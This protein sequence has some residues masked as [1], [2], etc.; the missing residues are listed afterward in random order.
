MPMP[1]THT[2]THTN[3]SK[4][5]EVR[6][7]YC[8]LPINLSSFLHFKLCSTARWQAVLISTHTV[9]TFT[10]WNINLS[11]ETSVISHSISHLSGGKKPVAVHRVRQPRSLVH[12]SWQCV[13]CEGQASRRWP[14]TVRQNVVHWSL[15]GTMGLL[16]GSVYDSVRSLTTDRGDGQARARHSACSNTHAY[17]QTETHIP[18]IHTDL[19]CSWLCRCTEAPAPPPWWDRPIG[20]KAKE[21]GAPMLGEHPWPQPSYTNR[22]AHYAHIHVSMHIHRSRPTSTHTHNHRHTLGVSN[23]IH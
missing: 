18:H 6:L 5:Q 8:F 17:W 15:G 1:K 20:T 4:E 13:Y 16:V 11:G 14:Y 2:Y 19:W 7:S 10:W 12:G 22:N 23:N 3:G 9:W 21:H